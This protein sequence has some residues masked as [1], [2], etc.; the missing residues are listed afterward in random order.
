MFHL[1]PSQHQ[2]CKISHMIRLINSADSQVMCNPE[3]LQLKQELFK[4]FHLIYMRLDNISRMVHADGR[5]KY[6]D[7]LPV[8][9]DSTFRGGNFD[10]VMT[11]FESDY[12]STNIYDASFRCKEMGLNREPGR[13]L[14][15][16]NV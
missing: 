9:N 16:Y 11:R 14:K 10:L 15:P 5:L 8:R 3:N 6:C 1:S 4:T 13:F 7:S 12:N 2:Y